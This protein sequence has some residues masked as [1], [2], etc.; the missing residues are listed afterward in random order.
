MKEFQGK[1]I[2]PA[3]AKFAVL[4]SRFNEFI[5]SKLLGGCTDALKRHGVAEDNIELVWAPGS[6]EIPVLAQKLAEH[7]GGLPG[8]DRI[9]P[10]GALPVETNSPS[11]ARICA[12]LSPST[13]RRQ[14]HCARPAFAE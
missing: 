3:D 12:R 6:F 10:A 2:A 1:L 14:G 8:I 9:T 13:A 11:R 4:V 5:T 7:L